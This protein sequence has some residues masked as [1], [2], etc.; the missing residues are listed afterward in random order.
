MALL[1]FLQ[2]PTPTVLTPRLV[3]VHY[4]GSWHST[5]MPSC[6]HPQCSCGKVMFLHLSVILFTRRGVCQTPAPG[7]TSPWQTPVRQTP[8]GQTPPRQ[9]QPWADTPKRRLLLR[10][11]RI[12]L[13]CILVFQVNLQP[14]SRVSTPSHFLLDLVMAPI[15]KQMFSWRKLAGRK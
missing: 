9:T 4:V 13:E 3:L 7:Q 15:S 2:G 12:L 5:E 11:V 14:P 1:P 10:A 6:Y 8:P